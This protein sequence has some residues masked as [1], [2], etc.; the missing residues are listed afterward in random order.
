MKLI[1]VDCNAC[2]AP[3]EVGRK[4]RFVTCRYC[5]K[6]LA[7]QHSDSSVY[8]EVLEEIK[9]ST[10]KISQDIGVIKLQNELEKLDREWLLERDGLMVTNRRGNRQLPSSPASTIV[11]SLV[12]ILFVFFF[13]RTASSMRAPA[14][15]P[16]FGVLVIIVALV[17]AS[18]AMF[19]TNGYQ[20]AE[21]RYQRQ[22]NELL[23]RLQKEEQG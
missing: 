16:L 14:I 1:T 23:Q 2:G 6:R 10:D 15:F 8:T 13:I 11:G 17:N 12:A 21:K 18:K 7:I 9:E 20:E 19:S 5:S 22:R 4:T 3:L